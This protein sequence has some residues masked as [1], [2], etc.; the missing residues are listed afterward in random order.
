MLPH[1]F[2]RNIMQHT[3][4]APR[5]V[6]FVLA[7]LML[8]LTLSAQQEVTKDTV[9]VEWISY[10][11]TTGAFLVIRESQFADG[12]FTASGQIVG[13]TA[14]TRTYLVNQV[15]DEQRG[16]ANA[17]AAVA[18]SGVNLAKL[19]IYSA[20]LQ[21]VGSLGYT[22]EIANQYFAVFEGRYRVVVP[23]QPNFTAWMIRLPNGNVRLEREDNQT[24]Y[25]VNL[26]SDRSFTV[27]NLPGATGDNKL[28]LTS[29]TTRDLPIYTTAMRNVRITRI[30]EDETAARA[31][32]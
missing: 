29:T 15:I 7:L 21:Q 18:N 26:F 16:E 12:S 20:I 31:N 25:T 24:R 13:D 22:N 19:N 6:Y 8:T 3:P 17:I 2:T 5:W 4:F 14:A 32:N 27:R 1:H 9:F 10:T 11:D 23:G 28:A 30:R